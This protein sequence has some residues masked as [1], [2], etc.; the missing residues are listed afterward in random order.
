MLKK[1]PKNPLTQRILI[2]LFKG[3]NLLIIGGYYRHHAI[4]NGSESSGIPLFDV[5][6]V[7]FN[8]EN[9][10]CDPLD[11]G[12]A[13]GDHASV[14]TSKGVITCGGST[15]NTSNFWDTMGTM[16]TTNCTLQTLLGQTTF[17]SLVE[18]RSWFGMVNVEGVIYAIGG[19]LSYMFHTM[20]TINIDTGI[21]W[22]IESLPFYE[23]NQCVV[24]I[25]TTI[26]VI[27]GWHARGRKVS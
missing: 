9:K 8:A 11:L 17:P 1:A 27:G 3:D 16:G 6:L 21:Q 22:K 7:N 20:E 2:Y 5:K 13:V 10:G 26:I 15:E 18:K 23:Y 19:D 12:Y 24:N 25:N 4:N 14:A